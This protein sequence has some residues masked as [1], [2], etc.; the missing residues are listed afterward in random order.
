MILQNKDFQRVV[1]EIKCFLSNLNNNESSAEIRDVLN[2]ALLHLHKFF[3]KVKNH[4]KSSTLNL[5]SS[6]SLQNSFGSQSLPLIIQPQDKFDWHWI[7][8]DSHVFSATFGYK[9]N[10]HEI[11]N[12]LKTADI[13][14]LKDLIE[15]DNSC[16]KEVDPLGRSTV[17]YCINGNEIGHLECLK[18]LLS[19]DVDLSHESQD[20]LGCVH[21]ASIMNNKA[22]LELIL[23]SKKITVNVKDHNGIFP[24][25]YAAGY[26]SV[27]FCKLLINSG[28][29]SHCLDND[30]MNPLMWACYFDK[31]ESLKLLCNLG[32]E[33]ETIFESFD[34]EVQLCDNKGRCVLHHS[35]M[36]SESNQCLRILLKPH[37]KEKIDNEGKNV[38]HYIAEH[39]ACEAL[40][41]YLQICGNDFLNSID[42]MGRTPLHLACICG[43][44]QIID[45][46]LNKGASLDLKDKQGFTPF[47]YARSKNL[48]YCHLVFQ[49]HQKYR[50]KNHVIDSKKVLSNS[51]L[52]Q[53]EKNPS[54]EETEQY[55]GR[56]ENPELK[57]NISLNSKRLSIDSNLD[58]DFD[59]HEGL[60]YD[61]DD[62]SFTEEDE[63][64]KNS[65]NDTVL[66]ILSPKLQAYQRNISQEGFEND[67]STIKDSH[68]GEF[69]HIKEEKLLGFNKKSSCDS[70]D[71]DDT[72]LDVDAE[73]GSI[74]PV[75]HSHLRNRKPTEI[76]NVKIGAKFDERKDSKPFKFDDGQKCK[77][78]VES[79]LALDFQENI[80]KR[81]SNQ[82]PSIAVNSQQPKP[83]ERKVLNDVIC[84]EEQHEWPKHSIY[85]SK[86]R[87]EISRNSQNRTY[88]LNNHKIKEHSSRFLE[89]SWPLL[90]KNHSMLE[91]K[92]K[93]LTN[94]VSLLPIH[95]PSATHL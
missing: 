65:H 11:F 56:T 64:Q 12:V 28:A 95:P 73:E 93:N 50:E 51:K 30:G 8:L 14:M 77:Q 70:S 55:K 31:A 91:E 86:R 84:N 87:I 79:K 22:A 49:Y 16:I 45:M 94:H 48:H 46:L 76:S 20:G 44:G 42:L 83:P 61:D 57:E 88:S 66:K 35:V 24:I 33:N 1:K 80:F 85:N 71:L 54:L 17:F 52:A 32:F 41:E 4:I 19:Y 62:S 58:E 3:K 27:D 75:P 10:V 2:F 47:D 90:N 74:S 59:V 18:I 43:H 36:K 34:T 92:P 69:S 67:I 9:K 25:H 21:L 7:N 26:A 37:Y 78:V 5:D 38:L 53:A 13:D 6:I 23:N 72:K 63:F 82:R 60:D 40:K 68:F 81:P 15:K 39:G 89:Q 29:D